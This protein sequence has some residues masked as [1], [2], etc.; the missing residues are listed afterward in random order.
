MP[1]QQQRLTLEEL[2]SYDFT[3]RQKERR[4]EALQMGEP[5][6][7]GDA[8]FVGEFSVMYDQAVV[9]ASQLMAENER[10]QA[11]LTEA[12]KPIY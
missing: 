6:Y 9:L 8:R 4:T 1:T 5:F 11:L 12:E 10:L 3:Q 7:Y 2:E